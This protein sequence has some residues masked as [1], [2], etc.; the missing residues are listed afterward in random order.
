[1]TQP[2]TNVLFIVADDL[3]VWGLGCYGNSEIRTPH[4]DAMAREGVRFTEF[5][6]TSPVC[7]P[8]RASLLTG[9]I[10][11]RHGVQDWIRSGNGR[12]DR[13]I[14]YLEDELTTTDVLAAAGYSCGLSGKWHLGDSPH[15]QHG[16]EHWFAHPSGGG[17]YNDAEMYRNGELVRTQGYLT[18]VLA[19][20]ASAFLAERAADQRPFHLWVT[21]TAPHSPWVDQ[22]PADLVSS[23]A[24]CVFDSCPQEPRHPWAPA[25]PIELDNSEQNASTDR[26]VVTVR[27]ELQGYFA[28]VTAL[29]R[30]VGRLRADLHELGLEEDTLVIFTSD[31]GFNC[32][33]HGIWG[34]GNA[35]FPQ[36]MYDTSVKVPFVATLPGRIPAGHVVEEMLSGYD[37]MPTVLDLVGLGHEVPA[38]LPGRSFR[39][40]LEGGAALTD[41]PVVIFDEFGPTRMIRNRR[42]KYVHR[43]PYG[44]HELYDLQHDPGERVN[45]L[46]DQ[47]V[48]DPAGDHRDEQ[49]AQLRRQLEEWFDRYTDPKRDGRTQAITGRGQVDIVGLPGVAAFHGPESQ[50]TLDSSYRPSTAPREDS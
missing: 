47:R 44:P 7:S 25:H 36:N 22:H 9:Q 37:V 10:P 41:R 8:S 28:A 43:Y 32:G 20:D 30:Q 23:Y 2:R 46:A 40:A 48:W 18:D 49:A 39:T 34:K 24:D 11:S 3:A 5:Y 14:R 12:G 31:N 13:A 50:K 6:C 4:I 16:H 38:D 26:P 45:L 15:P 21:F 42:W 29:D 17:R 35:T 27:D 33:H 19:D 1:M